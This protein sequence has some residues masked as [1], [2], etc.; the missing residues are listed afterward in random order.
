MI[1][2][3]DSV[4]ECVHPC[5]ATN[6][7]NGERPAHTTGGAVDITLTYNGTPLA[8]AQT[9]VSVLAWLLCQHMKTPRQIEDVKIRDLRRFLGSRLTEEDMAPYAP[10]WWHWSFGMM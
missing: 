7:Y 10:L 9:M 5:M 3:R 1:G 8:L 2:E 6:K 4:D